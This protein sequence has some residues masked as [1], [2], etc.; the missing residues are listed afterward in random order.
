MDRSGDPGGW[1]QAY[2]REDSAFRCARDHPVVLLV[3][4]VDPEL[5]VRLYGP[6]DLLMTQ[7]NE[8][9][10]THHDRTGHLLH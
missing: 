3:T 7:S 4:F 8:K 10:N 1:D 5:V 6:R 2:L 9:G